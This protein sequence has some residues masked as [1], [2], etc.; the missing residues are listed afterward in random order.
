MA[1]CSHCSVSILLVKYDFL[2]TDRTSST[3]NP[4]GQAYISEITCR[5]LKDGPASGIQFLQDDLYLGPKE[6]VR[7]PFRFDWTKELDCSLEPFLRRKVYIKM[8]LHIPS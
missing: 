6:L 4:K 1:I 2:A 7:R 3:P 8:D 5:L